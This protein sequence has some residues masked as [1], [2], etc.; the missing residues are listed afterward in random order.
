MSNQNQT[1]QMKNFMRF[2]ALSIIPL[3][4]N[5][6]SVCVFV[7]AL[8]ECVRNEVWVGVRACVCSRW[9]LDVCTCVRGSHG[10]RVC[11]RACMRVFAWG[12]RYALYDGTCVC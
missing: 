6:P 5:F 12:L 3:A 11:V 9:G 2:F 10:V 7:C 1:A 8:R 4:G